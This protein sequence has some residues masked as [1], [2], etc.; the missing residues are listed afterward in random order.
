[1]GS[2]PAKI[3]LDWPKNLSPPGIP[4]IFKQGLIQFIKS[5]KRQHPVFPLSLPVLS[6]PPASYNAVSQP[7]GGQHDNKE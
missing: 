5:G 3:C 1:G 6:F 4:P 7:R 2:P